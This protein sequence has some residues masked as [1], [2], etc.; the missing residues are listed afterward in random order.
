MP[1]AAT[2]ATPVNIYLRREVAE[3]ARANL[4][5]ESISFAIRFL[6]AKAAGLSDQAARESAQLNAKKDE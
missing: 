5:V 2:G 3:R 4:G 1:R 6:L